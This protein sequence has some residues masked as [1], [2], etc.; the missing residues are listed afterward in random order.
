MNLN[1]INIDFKDNIT[2]SQ[3]EENCKEDQEV[4]EKI[5]NDEKN[6]VRMLFYLKDNNIRLIKWY[7][8]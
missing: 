5:N 4:I 7:C 6:H 2:K 1:E 8:G 3:K